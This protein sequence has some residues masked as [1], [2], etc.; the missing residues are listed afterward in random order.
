[1][2]HNLILVKPSI[3]YHE[4]YL[5][6]Y[7]EWKSTGEDMVPWV[8]EKDPSDFI[9]YVSFLYSQ[10]SDEKISEN[11]WVPH[12][13]YWLVDSQHTILGAVNIR[14]RLNE[15]L[16]N[17]GG[18]IGYGIRPSQRRMGYATV[19]LLLTLEKTRALGLEKVLVVCNRGNIGSE[20]TIMKNGG[21]FESEF[22]EESG[23]I[24]RRF[25]I[26]I[27]AGGNKMMY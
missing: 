10:D 19:L 15:K 2:V 26:N 18:H 3:A 25:W 23:N 9:E 22:I 12:S 7:N 27:N 1:M 5:N 20:R 17:C 11:G 8:I 4:E 21:R 6:F 13:T 14:H 24:V 16:F